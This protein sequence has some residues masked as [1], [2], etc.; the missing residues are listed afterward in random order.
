MTDTPDMLAE[1]PARVNRVQ[2]IASAP[3]MDPP[4]ALVQ[5]LRKLQWIA[6]KTPLSAGEPVSAGHFFNAN[7]ASANPIHEMRDL[8]RM[9]DHALSPMQH[10]ILT[11]VLPMTATPIGPPLDKD[12]K[13]KVDKLLET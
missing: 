4:R 13:G 6:I 7:P 1:R 5:N 12:R 9:K 8:G 10:P 11:A 3:H 2:N